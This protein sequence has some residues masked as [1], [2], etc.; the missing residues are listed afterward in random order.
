[1]ASRGAAQV[2][3]GETHWASAAAVIWAGLC[4]GAPIGAFPACPGP[5][6]GLQAGVALVIPAVYDVVEGS[7]HKMVLGC[8]VAFRARRRGG[9]SGPVDMRAVYLP[10]TTRSQL[11]APAR[12]HSREG[13]AG[14]A[15]QRTRM[16]RYAGLMSGL[17]AAP[18]ILFGQPAMA[19]FRR[20]IDA[21]A[22]PVAVARRRRVRKAWGYGDL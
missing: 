11:L 18:S 19:A 20:P 2:A 1:M 13:G 14:R 15:L 8:S 4:P 21:V 17:G 22:V 10:R 7:Q 5:R 9:P 6:C 3:V 16:G 12:W